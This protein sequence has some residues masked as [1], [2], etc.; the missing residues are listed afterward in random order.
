MSRADA[1]G[2]ACIIVSTIQS[3]RREKNNGAPDEEGLKV[4]QDAGN[5]MDHF[6]GLTQAQEARLEP[7]E[8]AGRPIASFS[9]LLRL[10]RPI[11]IVD[12]AHN[13]RTALSFDTLAR[14][15]PSLILE[16]TATP[17]TEHNPARDKHASNILYSVSAAE[18]KAEE[19]IK[20][21]IKL[22]TDSNWQ[23]TIG[24]AY[25]CRAALEEAAKAEQAETGE[26]I[27]PII[28]FQAQSASATDATRIAYAQSTS[29]TSRCTQSS[30]RFRCIQKL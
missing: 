12:E 18:L 1:E 14:F 6:S 23:K 2:G 19:M 25:D 26:Y 15:S 27:R 5:L 13:A 30:L 4:Y 9:N 7:L 10:H 22:T 16:L 17:Q 20:M 21:P 11:V 8:G 28:L 29:Q 3:F 24:A